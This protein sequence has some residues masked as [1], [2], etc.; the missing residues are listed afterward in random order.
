MWSWMNGFINV[1]SHE[2]VVPH[3]DNTQE[4]AVSVRER[5]ITFFAIEETTSIQHPPAARTIRQ[6]ISHQYSRGAL[7]WCALTLSMF[8][9]CVLVPFINS[10]TYFVL[11]VSVSCTAFLCACFKILPQWLRCKTMYVLFNQ[12]LFAENLF[13]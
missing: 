11:Y 1:S 10:P 12:K 6:S 13:H 9:P 4:S 3:K 8:L 5:Q 2:D 7:L